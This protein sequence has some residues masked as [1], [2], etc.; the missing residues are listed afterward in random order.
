[1]TEDQDAKAARRKALKKLRETRGAN[2]A[3][4]AEK[5]KMQKKALGL[6]RGLLTGAGKTAPELAQLS[7]MPASEVLWYLASL[8]KYGEVFEGEKDGGYYRYYARPEPAS[9]EVAEA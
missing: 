1:M 2:V 3:A 4:A 7:G 9:S 6:L 5:V 8:K